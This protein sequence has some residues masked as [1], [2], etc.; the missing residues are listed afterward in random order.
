MKTT[1]TWLVSVIV[2]TLLASLLMYSFSAVSDHR[3]RSQSESAALDLIRQT[4]TNWQADTLLD[5][6]DERFR[7]EVPRAVLQRY[8]TALSNLGE[9][10]NLSVNSVSVESPAFWYWQQEIRADYVVDASF[11]GGP[12]SVEISLVRRN[13]QWQVSDFVVQAS[14]MAA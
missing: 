8:L 13:G 5:N 6:A 10:Q 14:L 7:M 12:A 2:L 11:S 1:L 3:A 9:L 4:V